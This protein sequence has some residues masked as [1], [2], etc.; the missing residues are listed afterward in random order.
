[1]GTF[2]FSGNHIKSLCTLNKLYPRTDSGY[3]SSNLLKV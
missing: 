1:M 2:Y 3:M